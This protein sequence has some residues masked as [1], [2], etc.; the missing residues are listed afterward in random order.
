MTSHDNGNLAPLADAQLGDL[1]TLPDGRSYSIRG[2]VRLTTPV[3]GIAGFV[4]AGECQVV[5]TTDTVSGGPIG[6]YLPGTLPAGAHITPIAEGALRYWAPHLP[7]ISGAMGELLWRLV[8]VSGHADPVVVLYRGE[9]VI[10]FIRSTFVWPGDV[11]VAT[12][13]RSTDNDRAVTRHRSVVNS[14]SSVP[15]TAPAEELYRTL[16]H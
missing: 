2:R 16:I 8:G 15:E 13:D 11:D 7:A 14:P 4:V 1:V 3:R 12:L 5:L 10:P 6:V 9:E